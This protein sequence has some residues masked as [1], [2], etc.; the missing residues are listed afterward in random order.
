MVSTLAIAALF[1]PLRNR[2]QE[3]VDRRFY[4]KKYDAQQVLSDFAQT[5][6]DETDLEKLTGRLIQVVQD[7]LQPTSISVWLDRTEDKAK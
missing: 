7:T 1:I 5:V 2:I 6:R 3:L 4:R